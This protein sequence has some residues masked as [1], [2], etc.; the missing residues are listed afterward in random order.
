[1]K[2]VEYGMRSVE[3]EVQNVEIT[4]KLI[5]LL[6]DY[7]IQIMSI[8]VYN[9]LFNYSLIDFLIASVLKI[10]IGFVFIHSKYKS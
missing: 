4:S 1:M 5:Y 7:I 3:C 2:S 10:L 8:I 9:N 6:F